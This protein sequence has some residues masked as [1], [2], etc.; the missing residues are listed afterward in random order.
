[1][2]YLVL[3]FCGLTFI[4]GDKKV[5]VTLLA[6]I[7]AAAVAASISWLFGYLIYIPRP[8][9]HDLGH[10]LLAHTDSASFPSN[11]MMFMSIFATMFTLSKQRK[12]ALLFIGL[13]LVIGWSRIYLGVHYPS[14]IMGG[15]IIGTVVSIV[16]WKLLTLVMPLDD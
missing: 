2:P 5:R 15:A 10:T 4:L 6:I 1:M 13:A 11:H 16:T 14:D 7:L 9:V 3:G 8:F 12:S